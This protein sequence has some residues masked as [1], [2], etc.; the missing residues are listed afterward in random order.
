[1]AVTYNVTS[2]TLLPGGEVI[3]R[4]SCVFGTYETSTGDPLNLSN[5]LLST[6]YPSVTISSAAGYVFEHDQGT[7]AAGAVVA[8]EVGAARI[9][10]T[11]G[12]LTQVV[13]A[14]DLSAVNAVFT[15]QGLAS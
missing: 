5:D 3:L 9:N 4:G 8:Y 10:A 2:T 13:N 6:G 15:I 11:I 7:A 12:A 14:T 1:M